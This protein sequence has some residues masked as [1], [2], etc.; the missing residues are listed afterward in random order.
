MNLESTKAT[1]VK[2]NEFSFFMAYVT[3]K[4]K[5]IIPQ[6][7]KIITKIKKY[8]LLNRNYNEN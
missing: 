5:Q 7:K 4:V 8:N 3:L 2:N 6:K 1:K